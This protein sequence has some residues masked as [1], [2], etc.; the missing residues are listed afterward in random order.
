[1]YG[2]ERR[3]DVWQARPGWVWPGTVLRGK[4]RQAWTVQN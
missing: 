3:G 4:E 1:M 2:M